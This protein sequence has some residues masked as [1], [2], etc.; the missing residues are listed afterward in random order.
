MQQ[1][2]ASQS[3]ESGPRLLFSYLK[4]LPLA[5]PF[6][7]C[8]VCVCEERPTSRHF[9]FCQPLQKALQNQAVA[10]LASSARVPPSP[11]LPSQP[12][13]HT[14]PP[15]SHL[16]SRRPALRCWWA[17]RCGAEQEAL[18]ILNRSMGQP[19]AMSCRTTWPHASLSHSDC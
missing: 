18:G 15:H 7:F 16:P 4:S 9:P 5:F 12:H 10:C 6:E 14:A 17:S 8:L 1:I 13:P 2:Q 19:V 3:K 11:S